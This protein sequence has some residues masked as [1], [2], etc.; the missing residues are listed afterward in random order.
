MN[1]VVKVERGIGKIELKQVPEPVA[2]PDQVKIEVRAAGICGTD[3]H[4][5][6][7]E[8][9]YNPPVIL[10]HEFSGVIAE[11]GEGVAGFK[12]G[13]RVTSETAGVI[14][15]TCRY[16]RTGNYNLCIERL[17]IG[18]G[19][20]GAF[21]RYCIVRKDIVHQLP[22]NVDFT[23]GALCEPLSCCVHGVIEQTGVAAGD[24]VVIHGA[25]VIGLL[26]LQVAKAEGCRVVVLGLSADRERLK[27]ARQLG[28]D[29]TANIEDDDAEKLVNTLSGGYGADV[30]LECSGSEKAVS[31]GLE[32]IRKRGKFTQIG[33]FG[34]PIRIDFEKIAYKELRVIGTV[35]QKR[36]AWKLA[37]MLLKEGKV[38]TAPLVTDRFPLKRWK[39]AFQKF[40]A[41]ESGKILLIQD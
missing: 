5:W 34:H 14:C 41:K 9:F 21:T 29:E 17:G 11:I 39:E 18:C 23:S 16:C 37:L 12:V 24:L 40:E 3:L 2:G 15:G 1:A 25:G 7:D 6:H 20:D 26:S 4:I 19:I 31:L 13:D 22:E 10:G 35:S 32:I 28:A 36:S 27:I 33:L 30:V 8:F 38:R